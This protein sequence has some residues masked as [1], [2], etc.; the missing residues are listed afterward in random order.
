MKQQQK[1]RQIKPS[2]PVLYQYPVRNP[3]HVPC[4]FSCAAERGG[5][6]QHSLRESSREKGGGAEEAAARRENKKSGNGKG[7]SVS[8]TAES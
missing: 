6:V 1:K 4:T 8:A 7:L 3:A 5:K 2:F